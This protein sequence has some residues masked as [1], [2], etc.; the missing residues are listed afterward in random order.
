MHPFTH[1]A[2]DRAPKHRC[3]NIFWWRI[4]Q[5]AG[6]PARANFESHS[7]RVQLNR[8][9]AFALIPSRA[10]WHPSASSVFDPQCL[11]HRLKNQPCFLQPGNEWKSTTWSHQRAKCRPDLA[12]FDHGPIYWSNPE[13]SLSIRY[14]TPKARDGSCRG[15]L[16]SSAWN[17]R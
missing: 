3:G 12:G 5:S 7:V 10:N 1:L 8:A 11:A 15:I 14:W 2:D 4:V 16:I 17:E 9:G 13:R 6:R